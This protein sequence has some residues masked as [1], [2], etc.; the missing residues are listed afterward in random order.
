M[1]G[2]RCRIR[3]YD[4][5][6]VKVN[7]VRQQPTPR[8]RVLS[9]STRRSSGAIA[10]SKA[11]DPALRG[12]SGFVLGSISPSFR[13]VL[14]IEI[15]AKDVTLASPDHHI[16]VPI[17]SRRE[18]SPRTVR[19]GRRWKPRAAAA[20]PG[21]TASARS[22]FRSGRSPDRGPRLPRSTGGSALPLRREAGSRARRAEEQ[23]ESQGTERR[24][25]LRRRAAGSRPA[26]TPRPRRPDVTCF[27]P[28]DLG[29]ARRGLVLQRAGTENVPRA[30]PQDS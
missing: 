11:P 14:V 19:E 15:P 26:P 29:V 28:N 9:S 10:A 13:H 20:P 17:L 1:D 2:G 21:R 30:T 3:T 12:V 7:P 22:V 27:S 6:R 24:S 18:P 16:S 23:Q 25:L 8:L 5:H 4:F